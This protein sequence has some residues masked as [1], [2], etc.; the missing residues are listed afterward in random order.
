MSHA[1]FNEY[2]KTIQPVKR[3]PKFWN[4]DQIADMESKFYSKGYRFVTCNLRA[5]HNGALHNAWTVPREHVGLLIEFLFKQRIMVETESIGKGKANI[6]FVCD[7]SASRFK[8]F[9][10]RLPVVEDEL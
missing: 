9:I 6:I 8:E 4:M 3:N 1:Y 2:Q 7:E 5:D 10:G